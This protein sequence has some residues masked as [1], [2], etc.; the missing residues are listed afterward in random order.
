MPRKQWGRSRAGH[1]PRIPGPG[2]THSSKESTET[3]LNKLDQK[4]ELVLCLHPLAGFLTS[5]ER[6]KGGHPEP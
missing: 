6:D 2:P 5:I 4:S 1:T 3:R